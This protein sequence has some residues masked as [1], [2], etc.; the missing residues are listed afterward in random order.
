MANEEICNIWRN[1]GENIN[2]NGNIN[3]E[4]MWRSWRNN[5]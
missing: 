3:R 4:I 5:S 1:N 2:E